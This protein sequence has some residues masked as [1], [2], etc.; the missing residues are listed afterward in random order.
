MVEEPATA[1]QIG[2]SSGVFWVSQNQSFEPEREGGLLFAPR[3]SQNGGPPKRH[4]SSMTK[5]RPSSLVLCSANRLLDFVAI[6]R[7]PAKVVESPAG[8]T[9]WP[10]PGWR[11]DVTYY[12]LDD[13][14]RIYDE[15]PEEL[16]ISEQPRF[17]HSKRYGAIL[18]QQYLNELSSSFARTLLLL[19]ADRWPV[20]VREMMDGAAPEF[21][22]E[23]RYQAPTVT[24]RRP[25]DI[26]RGDRREP[27]QQVRTGFATVAD[28][29]HEPLIHDYWDWVGRPLQ[30]W[31]YSNGMRCDAFDPE[32]G[33]LIEAKPRLT[34]S[35]LQRAVGQLFIYRQLHQM[36]SDAPTVRN[37]MV[38]TETNPGREITQILASLGIG[39]AYRDESGFVESPTSQTSS[40]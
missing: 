30:E 16:R 29:I 2:G 31:T 28:L 37:L 22:G 9:Q 34:A 27:N 6:P 1:A 38:L 13:P 35:E 14:I 36:L 20:F 40:R 10:R 32:S 5:L 26:G 25:R 19:F 4:W 17:M 11:C 8:L 39:L 24:G 7:S 21:R 3:A 15:I 33:T 23:T 18:S 12:Q